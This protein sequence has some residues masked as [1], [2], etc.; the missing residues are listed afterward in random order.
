MKK[1]ISFVLV[2]TS[3]NSF[4]SSPFWMGMGSTTHNFLTAQVDEKGTT[5]VIEFAPTVIVGLNIP[6]IY[7]GLSLTPGIGYATFS[8]KD[9]TSKNEY[10]LQYHLTQELTSWFLFQFGLSNYITNIGGTGG[11]ISL[12]NGSGTATF[13]TPAAA[14]ISYTSSM[15]IGGELVLTNSISTRLQFSILRFLSSERRRVSH[16]LTLNYFF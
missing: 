13:Y 7:S 12:K 11:T 10:I 15:D 5:K 14:K 3:L 2:L 6:F 1:I 9:N 8:T 4:A 16:L